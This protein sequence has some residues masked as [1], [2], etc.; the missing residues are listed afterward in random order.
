MR[1]EVGLDGVALAA[2][3]ARPALLPVLSAE[4][5]LDPGE[6]TEGSRRGVVHAAWLGAHVNP[7]ARRS[8]ARPALP[9]PPG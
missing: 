7:A 1:L 5:L 4:V 2:A 3:R 6:V 8:G 9:Q